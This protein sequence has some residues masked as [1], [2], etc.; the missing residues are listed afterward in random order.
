M[1]IGC[2]TELKR[3]DM[4]AHEQDDKL[5]LHMALEKVNLE[6][7]TLKNGGSTTYS[8]PDFDKMKNANKLIIF[9]PFY[10]HSPQG[11]P[12]VTGSVC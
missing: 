4:A 3:E 1:G 12:H 9:P 7:Q 5:H 11:I 10:V 8:L 6:S 2:D